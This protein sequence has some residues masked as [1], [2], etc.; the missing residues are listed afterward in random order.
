MEDMNK[1]LS[2]GDIDAIVEKVVAKMQ[3]INAA[4]NQ[5]VEVKSE[6]PKTKSEDHGNKGFD[7]MLKLLSLKLM[8]RDEQDIKFDNEMTGLIKNL[9]DRL[10][11]STSGDIKFDCNLK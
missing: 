11:F 1:T 9:S 4:N 2:D 6:Q 5:V 10:S 8:G 3:E 7:T